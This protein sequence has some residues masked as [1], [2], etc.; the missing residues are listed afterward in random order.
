MDVN[1]E[2][3]GEPLSP[4][5]TCAIGTPAPDGA[6]LLQSLC[7]QLVPRRLAALACLSFPDVMDFA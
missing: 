4:P 5:H 7:H 2:F 6:P 1:G 3:M